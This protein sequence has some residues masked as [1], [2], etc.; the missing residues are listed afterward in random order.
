MYGSPETQIVVFPFAVLY[1]LLHAGPLFRHRY[2]PSIIGGTDWRF[3]ASEVVLF[4]AYLLLAPD[5]VAH[6]LGQL[7]LAVHLSLHVAFTITD[8][9]AHE[10]LL[11]TA[12]VP[13][14]R[15]PVMWL[16]KEGG[17]LIDTTTHA[18]AVVL[19]AQAI[20]LWAAI[21]WLPVSVGVFWLWSNGYVRRF[22]RAA[23]VP[24]PVR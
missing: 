21:G 6:P 1:L 15:S 8:Y 11:G 18:I 2:E 24:Q 3:F 12:L 16:A 10:F 22:G 23:A 4:T 19:L 17:L 5:L 20:P 7:A 14:A 9:V 13:W